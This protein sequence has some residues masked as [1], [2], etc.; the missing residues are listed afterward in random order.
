VPALNRIKL[1]R[2]GVF[3][4]MDKPD[5]H[6]IHV[7]IA[8]PSLK[9]FSDL[10]NTLAADTNYQAAAKGIFSR[11]PKDPAYTRIESH[12]MKAFTSIPVM[13]L[14]AATK[15]RK[16]RIFELRTYESPNT[17]A[18]YRKVDMFNSGETQIM[19]DVKLAPVFFGE[20]LVGGQ[21]P[22]LTYMLSADN[23]EAHKE[24]WKGFLA[25]PE[26]KRIKVIPKYKGTVSKIHKTY[27]V[28]T[29]YSQ[30]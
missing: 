23:M 10:S 15:A 17:N 30:I 25:H 28:P 27:L 7:L 21:V 19:R 9:V 6:S 22:N 14:P 29:A 12:L 1:D 2:V 11:P 20:M 13:E 24:H 18:A 8:Y 3:T 5:D 4:T 16:P 26:W